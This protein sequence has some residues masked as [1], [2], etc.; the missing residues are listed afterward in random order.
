MSTSAT[1]RV[2]DENGAG[3]AGLGVR[4][5]D[6]SQLLVVSLAKGATNNTGNFSLTYADSVSGNQPG[7]QLRTLRLRVLVGE[8]PI[9]EVVQSDT[10]DS[11]LAFATIQATVA[12][13]TSWWATL[14]TGAPSRLSHSNA[15]RWL[16]DN[17]DAW[18]HTQ[19]VIS[20]ASTLD[21]M[22]LSIDIDEFCHD[23]HIEKPL[24][25]LQFDP[26][27]P[28]SASNR[29]KMNEFDQ[30]IERSILAR[31]QTG[32][33][34]RIQIPCMSVDAHAAAAALGITSFIGITGLGAL[35]LLGG[36]IGWL[37]FLVGALIF[38]ASVIGLI[39]AVKWGLPDMFKRKRLAR[40]FE[41]AIADLQAGSPSHPP[42]TGLGKVRVSELKLRSNNVTHSKLVI[43]RGVEAV[44]LGSPFSQDYFGDPQHVFDDPRRGGDASKA[45]IHEMSVAV[46]GGAVGHLEEVFNNHWNIATPDDKL[47]VTPPIPSAP[48]S[49]K[50]GEFLASVQV[51][52]TF[53]KMF[54]PATDGEQGVLEAYL[55]AIH[56]AE[57]FIY[58][59]NQYF[60][61]DTITEALVAAL[62]KKPAL[63]L[64]LLLNAC[65][66]M[67]LYMNWQQKA[68]KRILGSFG[69]A[70]TAKKR[71][72]VFS[73]WVHASKE[74]LGQSNPNIVDIYLHTKSALIDNRWA[75]VGSANL[76]GASLD[77]IQYERAFF[78]SDVRN[79]EANLVV[80]EDAGTV[81]SAVDA[82]RRRMWAEHLG[83]SNPA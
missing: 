64:I 15:I 37:L 78:D 51:V 83:V 74:S 46:R 57:R 31:V 6:I 41:Q 18:G 24:I 65:P 44:V 36:V 50:D 68:I 23:F 54:A 17:V 58:I 3:I 10:L 21:I 13:A 28:M 20:R 45:P 63:Q 19:D 40:W 14:G 61:N 29:R 69:D 42:A 16:V 38:L 39:Y 4:L 66:D 1:G 26:N 7:K 81:V 53:D 25:V 79:T 47:L 55:R 48:T 62:K 34:V 59:E 71:V 70:A 35:M 67:P 8:H 56:L 5:E 32:V 73:P 82:L 9:R 72:G 80:F 52:R 33:D 2:I 22:Q 75:T 11:T 43:D 30:R 12:E 27:N 77:Y 60:N 49:L 76:D